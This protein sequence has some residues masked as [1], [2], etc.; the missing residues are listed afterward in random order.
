MCYFGSLKTAGVSNSLG[1]FQFFFLLINNIENVEK[2]YFHVSI[3]FAPS[4]CLGIFEFS[5][6]RT[7]GVEKLQKNRIIITRALE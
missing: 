4:V 5:S 7:T 3:F 1:Y 2:S 6:F